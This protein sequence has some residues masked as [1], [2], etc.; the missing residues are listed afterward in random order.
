VTAVSVGLPLLVTLIAIALFFDFLNG[1][2][3]AANSIATVVSTRV[4]APRVAVVWAAFFNFI[5]FLFFGLHVANTIG[6]GIVAADAVDPA[7]IGGALIG[8][9]AWNVATWIWGIPSSSSHA[10]VGGLIGAAIAKAGFWAVLW[11]GV[12]TVAA[13]I[14]ISPLLGFFL[15]LLLVLITSWAARR[16]TPYA[17][18]HPPPPPGGPA[19]AHPTWG[20]PPASGCSNSSPPPSSAWA[21]AA[22]MRR[23]PWASSPSS[24]SPRG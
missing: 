10:L 8:A 1:L 22:T 19:P 2:H 3:D 16:S 5:A 18:A 13:F 14:V 11:G 9:I 17:V 4:L 15:A 20:T 23:K 24:S 21:T 12:G 7:V 6:K